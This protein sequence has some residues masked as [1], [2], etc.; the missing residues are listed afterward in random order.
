MNVDRLKKTRKMVKSRH[1]NIKPLNH[2]RREEQAAMRQK[3]QMENAKASGAIFIRIYGLLLLIV[4][5]YLWVSVFDSDAMGGLGLISG[6]ILAGVFKIAY[7]GGL[8]RNNRSQKYVFAVFL[9]ALFWM[10]YTPALKIFSLMLLP[11]LISAFWLVGFMTFE[12]IS[13]SQNEQT[14]WWFRKK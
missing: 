9:V 11:A 7:P 10:M 6:I 5:L 4:S 3:A 14:A 12:N 8:D 2:H 13:R 1:P